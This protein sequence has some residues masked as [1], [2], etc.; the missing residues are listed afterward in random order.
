MEKI[1][2]RKVKGRPVYRTASR[3]LDLGLSSL[4][5][6]LFSPPAFILSGK[7]QIRRRRAGFLF[8]DPPGP[9]RTDF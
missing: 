2:Y 3:L 5:L 8:A 4:G 7:D 9:R 6:A 1:N